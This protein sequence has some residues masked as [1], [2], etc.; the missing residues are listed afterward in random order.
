MLQKD[1][2]K[3]CKSGDFGTNKFKWVSW[4]KVSKTNEK[5]HRKYR[6]TQ[7][8]KIVFLL[9]SRTPKHEKQHKKK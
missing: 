2:P 8:S 9:A 1:V 4:Q 5:S 6:I 3:K 7:R